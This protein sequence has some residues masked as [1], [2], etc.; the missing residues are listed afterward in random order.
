MVG[1]IGPPGVGKSTILNEIYGSDSSSPG[2]M[3]PF[4]VES[5]ETRAMARHCTVGIEPRISS[6]RIILLDTQPVFSP[7]VLAEM[8]R[9]DGSSTLSVISGESLSAELAHEVMSIQELL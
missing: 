5:E 8:I 9:P 4:V 3:S 1:V 7:S 6:E 2:M